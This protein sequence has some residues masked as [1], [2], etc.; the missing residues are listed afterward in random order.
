MGS[1]VT[2]LRLKWC[3]ESEW[4]NAASLRRLNASQRYAIVDRPQ[5][6]AY[7]LLFRKTEIAI[8]FV[9]DWLR[10]AEDPEA[11]IGFD[12]NNVTT[13]SPDHAEVEVP[14]FQKHQADQSIFSVLFKERGFRAVTLQEGH[15]YVKLARWRE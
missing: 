8:S 2:A 12:A 10:E 15:K 9:K 11:L 5:I 4:T 1:D 14:G 7:L 13:K 6:G 3:L